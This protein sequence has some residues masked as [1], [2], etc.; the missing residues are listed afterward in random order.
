[1]KRIS[2]LCI[3]LTVLAFSLTFFVQATES[4]TITIESAEEFMEFSKNC[5][6]DSY[7]KG[8][9]VDLQSDIDLSEFSFQGI[10]IF[11]GEFNGNGFSIS[12]ISIS[13]SGSHYGLF[14][15]LTDTAFIHDLNIKGQ[16]TPNGSAA[17]IGAI[18]GSNAG[19]IDNCHVSATIQG[20][21]FAGGIAG[22]NTQTGMIKNCSFSGT[23]TAKHFVG[24]ITG[25]NQG[26][27]SGCTNLASVNDQ[28]LDDTIDLSQITMESLTGSESVTAV[29]DVG[30]IAGISSGSIS[31]CQ[32]EGSIGY[33]QVGY[34][35]GGITGR[36]SGYITNCTNLGVISGRKEV[37]GIAGQLEPSIT[38]SYSTDTLQ[39]LKQ[40]IQNL[41][42]LIER[43]G[44]SFD[45]TTNSIQKEITVLQGEIEKALSVFENMMPED[46][47][48]APPEIE[49]VM[50]ATDTLR[51]LLQSLRNILNNIRQIISSSQEGLSKDL[52]AI[53]NAADAIAYTIDHAGDRLGGSISDVSD[54]DSDSLSSVISQCSN[55]GTIH[56]DRNGGGIVGA[57]NFENDL[58]PEDDI[59]V[60][61]DATLHFSGTYRAVISDCQNTASVFVKKQHGGGIA[62]FAPLG[63][64]QKC[65]NHANL[66]CDNASYVGGIAG[67]SDGYIRNCDA[68]CIIKAKSYAGGIAGYGHT[69]SDC[70]VISHI[71]ANE[72]L[73]S[74]LG[75]A[76]DLT[77]LSGN[78][79]LS[80]IALGAVDNI[81]YENAAQSTT[82]EML[83][84]NP[85]IPDYFHT[86]R[87]TFVFFDGATKDMELTTGEILADSQIPAL[88][89][90]DGCTGEWVDLDQITFFDRQITCSYETI[91]RV[92]QST[93]TREN[94]LPVILAEGKFLPD[95]KIT[96]SKT[97]GMDNSIEA[98]T[99]S[100][101][102]AATLRYQ[103]PDGYS[104]DNLTVYC[105]NSDNSWE[106]VD[107][108]VDG[109]YIV[110]S[111]C[112]DS[113][114]FSIL[115]S[116]TFP[117][118][119]LIL[120]AAVIVI[121]ISL[122]AILVIRKRKRNTVK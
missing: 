37:G 95:H 70:H 62:G 54:E 113:T 46:D 52:Q 94:G 89:E 118:W 87:V 82:P 7:S 14:R 24:G 117:W 20:N 25:S 108:K 91:T 42:S 67:R 1:M 40:Q 16:F 79:F 112:G 12:G 27:I 120:A 99:V 6:I 119:I 34:N 88:P 109:R 51:E 116:H 9:K 8:L 76:E 93:E 30:G 111:T 85:D 4:G 50:Q 64:M 63:L 21:E 75:Q 23:V 73:G 61:G 72:A 69:V 55:S 29:T 96:I 115:P 44:S 41:T 47:L 97:D 98:W 28:P 57:I 43:T 10:P 81:S 106:R 121:S 33:P 103:I 83:L 2:F 92:I 59:T 13:E 19:E 104:G 11:C 107:T 90:L 17:Y 77:C 68:K 105:L 49:E 60:S 80:P 74:V 78:L 102:Y 18:A 48:F 56:A 3:L 100:T 15:Y 58:D 122:T 5:S 39:I 84:S 35:V 114:V 38:I 36:Q 53:S 31:D 66:I 32:N 45:E 22:I 86:F 26:I 101:E 110:F 71:E 65:H